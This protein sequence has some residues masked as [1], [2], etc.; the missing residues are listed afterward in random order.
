MINFKLEKQ[1]LTKLNLLKSNTFFIKL[2]DIEYGITCI[3]YLANS[4]I[5]FRINATS[6]NLVSENEFQDQSLVECD[7]DII[8]K[9]KLGIV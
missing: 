7:L 3:Y 1:K 8:A 4:G 5:I 9:P 2:I 6:L